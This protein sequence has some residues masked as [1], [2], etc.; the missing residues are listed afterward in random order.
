VIVIWS[1]NCRELVYGGPEE[2]EWYECEVGK[3]YGGIC[4]EAVLRGRVGRVDP[5]LEKDGRVLFLG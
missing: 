2:V 1:G 3:V 5:L 4:S